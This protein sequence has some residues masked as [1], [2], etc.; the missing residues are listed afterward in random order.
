[1]A[2]KK[3]LV[4]L[5]A[6]SSLD[7]GMPSVTDID[8]CMKV[9]GTEWMNS[10]PALPDADNYFE[11]LWRGAETYYRS[12]SPSFG[13]RPNFEKIL[14]DMVA[15]AN[16]MQPAPFGNTLRQIVCSDRTP[17]DVHFPFPEGSAPYGA[18]IIINSQLGYLLKRLAEHFRARSR[19]LDQNTQA[20]ARYR[21]LIAAL[22]KTFDVGIYN[23][24]YDNVALAA[25]PDAFT[26]FADNG[27]F[28]TG[29]VH[30]RHEWGF[31]YHL[32]GSVHHTLN[33]PFVEAIQ[34]QHDLNAPFRDG[35]EGQATNT[36][37][38][39]K[40]F[41][42]ATFI[43]GGFK[44][45][46]LLIEPFHSFYASLVRHVYEADAILIGGYGFGETHVNRALQ[47]RLERDAAR[48]LID[49]PPVMI[50]TRSSDSERHMDSRQ[51]MWSMEMRRS[52][53]ASGFQSKTIGPFDPTKA[54][55][56]V[57]GNAFEFSSAHRVALWHGGF[58]ESA[59]HVDR[60]VSWLSKGSF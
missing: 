47:N 27:R 34:W 60:V 20:F 35:D 52:L 48:G 5:G 40:S 21:H 28:D 14:G 24:N 31:S 53:C 38:E 58:V 9:W 25:W 46:Q 13:M 56:L 19:A 37:S 42:R 26:G 22:R 23:L 41:P 33:G 3:L 36:L 51:D 1:M 11:K 8:N 12:N 57:P 43:A 49:R 32:H 55:N 10:D 50:L 29:A 15:L 16:W 6:G 39:Q 45:D 7:Q 44:L 17:P 4:I 30:R 59:D 54:A 18:Y 2:G